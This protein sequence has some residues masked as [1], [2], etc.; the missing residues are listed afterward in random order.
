MRTTLRA[1]CGFGR[2][3]LLAGGL[4][5]ALASPARAQ[6]DAAQPPVSATAYIL[7]A[8]TGGALKN[9]GFGTVLPDDSVE[10]LAVSAGVV[11]E[12]SGKWE[13]SFSAGVKKVTI[14]FVLPDSLVH[15]SDPSRK[16]PLS[17]AGNSYG[18][19][20]EV[21]STGVCSNVVA[22]NPDLYRFGTSSYTYTLTNV[23]N[24]KKVYVHLGGKVKA[25]GPSLKPGT[26]AATVTLRFYT[27]TK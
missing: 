4:V 25:Q 27:S 9:L 18:G 16:I 22:I 7:E 5:L 23:A 8:L 12:G 19:L 24:T 13:I 10:V 14:A 26:Y 1:T 20:C 21:S 6:W 2:L 17:W 3:L 11:N 15:T